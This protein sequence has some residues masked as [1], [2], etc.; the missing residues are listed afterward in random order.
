MKFRSIA[1]VVGTSVAVLFLLAP[2]HADKPEIFRYAI[3]FDFGPIVECNDFE[4]WTRGWERDTEKWWY[5]RTGMPVRLQVTINITES[6]YYNTSTDKFVSQGKKGVGENIMIDYDI[7]GV[8]EF[9]FLIFGDNHQAGAP[10]RLTIPGIG[11]VLLDAGTWF[12]DAAEQMLIHHGP[13]YALAEGETG[14]ALC[15]ALE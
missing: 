13:D 14:L 1:S 11:H 12:W 8:D 10:F 15:E 2:A 3:S 4:V 9:G 5:D 6:E 7:I